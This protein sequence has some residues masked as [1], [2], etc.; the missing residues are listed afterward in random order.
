LTLLGRGK[1]GVE[2]I[3]YRSFRTTYWS[4]FQGSRIQKVS[5]LQGSKPWSR[6]R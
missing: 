5:Q 1:K 6:D 2:V 3:S 4:H